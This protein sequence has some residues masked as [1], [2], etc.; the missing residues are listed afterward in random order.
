MTTFYLCCSDIDWRKIM[1][2]PIVSSWTKFQSVEGRGLN[3][4][5][6]QRT[7]KLFACKR[8]EIRDLITMLSV[9]N[10]AQTVA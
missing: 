7:T 10:Q 3:W 9:R 6:R 5:W 8:Y 4:N 1:A 2:M